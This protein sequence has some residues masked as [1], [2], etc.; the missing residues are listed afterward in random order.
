MDIDIEEIIDDY[1]ESHTLIKAKRIYKN[2]LVDFQNS[3]NKFYKFGCRSETVKHL[4][5]EVEID[6]SDEEEPVTFCTCPQY[7]YDDYC[8]HVVACLL[9]LQNIDGVPSSET[10]EEKNKPSTTSQ[11]KTPL[12]TL[13]V[14][15]LNYLDDWMIFIGIGYYEKNKLRERVKKNDVV[16][17]LHETTQKSLKAIVK[18]ADKKNAYEINL[19]KEG[20]EITALCQCSTHKVVCIH[21]TTLLYY[22]LYTKRTHIT[23]IP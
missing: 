17:I 7:E 14:Y 23:L 2:G 11:K 16:A 8:K 10:A 22:L 3:E 1:A 13:Q 12:V 18:D 21:T 6:F 5:Y 4:L 9:Y 20:N 19:K 15:K